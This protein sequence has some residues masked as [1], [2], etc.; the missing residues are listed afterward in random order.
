VYFVSSSTRTMW[1]QSETQERQQATSARNGSVATVDEIKDSP[2]QGHGDGNSQ[3]G[4]TFGYSIPC[5]PE[6]ILRHIHSLMPMDAAARAACVSRTFLSSWRCYP[7]L[8][9]NSETVKAHNTSLGRRIHR[10]LRNHSGIGLKILELHLSDLYD[11]FP[12]LDR[13][14]HDA[15]TPGIEELTLKLYKG[16]SFP[17]SVLSGG[18]RSSIRSLD[19]YSCVFCP[20]AELGPF[21]S[22]TSLCLY[23]VCI[24][25]DELGCLLSNSLA[26]ERLVLSDCKEIISLEIPSV[27][28][29]LSYMSVVCCSALQIIENKAPSLS[30]F[31]LIPGVRNLSLGEASQTMKEL[32]L[33]RANAICYGRAELPSIMPNLESLLL[34]SSHEVD[35]PMLPTKFVNLKHLYLQ[36]IS[37]ALSPTCDYSSLVSFLDASPFLE[38]W[39]LQAPLIDMGN[40][41][42]GSSDLRQLPERQHHHLKIVEMITFKST[43]SLVELTCCIVKSAVSLERLTFDTFRGDVRSPCC[44]G[45]DSVV[46]YSKYRM[47]QASRAVEAI[48]MYIE[49]KVA[50]TTKLTVL[51][52]CARCHATAFDD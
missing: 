51:E 6:D 46:G 21:R 36:I 3:D 17:C 40:E 33:F 9:L 25:G 50:P 42:V 15:I 34:C 48:R 10:I 7:K 5:L 8:I 18:I 37:S 14:L 26:L 1:I 35:I 47:E 4:Q 19:L 41:L 27:M 30:S 11:F 39:R 23:S 43:Q 16:F 13:W 28:Q 44:S 32:S 22:L 29:K 20:T 31:H 45:D 12:Y 52:P 38:T 24:T 49:D 2:C